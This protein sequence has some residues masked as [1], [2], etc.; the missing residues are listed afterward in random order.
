MVHSIFCDHLTALGDNQLPADSHSAW[1]LHA[2]ACMHTSIPV[3]QLIVTAHSS[4]HQNFAGRRSLENLYGPNMSWP[5][6]PNL[7]EH[8]KSQET[9]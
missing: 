6:S 8:K 1:K 4:G 7:E 2:S 9:F 5:K 3:R